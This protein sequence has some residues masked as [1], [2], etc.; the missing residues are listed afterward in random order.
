MNPPLSVPR[1]VALIATR[2]QR[3]LDQA[4]TG[5]GRRTSAGFEAGGSNLMMLARLGKEVRPQL[6]VVDALRDLLNEVS[7]LCLEFRRTFS[8]SPLPENLAQLPKDVWQDS[9]GAQTLG[10]RQ[11]VSQRPLGFSPVSGRRKRL[12]PEQVSVCCELASL[13]PVY[14]ADDLT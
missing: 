12:T 14:Q 7:G 13:K 10:F 1:Y 2:S 9:S 8:V 4:L 11:S 5:V 6:L 3:L